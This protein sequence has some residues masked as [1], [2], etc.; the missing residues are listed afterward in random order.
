MECQVI[1]N[2]T[3]QRYGQLNKLSTDKIDFILNNEICI[4]NV[5]S[6]MN[7]INITGKFSQELGPGI[8]FIKYGNYEWE[9]HGIGLHTYNKLVIYSMRKQSSFDNIDVKIKIWFPKICK[10]EDKCRKIYT[11]IFENMNGAEKLPDHYE[12]EGNDE[13]DMRHGW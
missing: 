1:I 10:Y 9:T 5:P 4:I 2:L 3:D 13:V 7:C 11:V 6:S 8:C 12:H